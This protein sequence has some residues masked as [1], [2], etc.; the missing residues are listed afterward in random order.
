[1]QIRR[2]I[3]GRAA[4]MGLVGF[5][6]LAAFL[7]TAGSLS[8]AQA[9]VPAF[10]FGG[11]QFV[12]KFDVKGIAPNRQVEFG[13]SNETL[14]GWTR[15]V[16]LFSF[17]KT[18]NDASRAAAVLANLVRERHKGAKYRVISN[19]KT[20]EAI[21][22]FLIP[23]PNSELM[24]FNVFKYTPAGNELVAL[25]FARRVKLGEID[26]DELREIRKTALDEMARYEMQPVKAFF[27]KAQ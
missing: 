7:L 12:Q 3:P 8:T 14:E 22:D 24:E 4:Y 9:Q 5:M 25:Q 10:R 6:G 1:M 16:T 2:A 27:G 17:T 15:L 11:E 26:A 19:P 21:I 20:G 23:V 13:L 18:G